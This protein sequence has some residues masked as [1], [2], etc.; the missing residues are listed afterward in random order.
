MLHVLSHLQKLD[1]KKKMD[2]NRNG[3]LLGKPVGDGKREK[4]MERKIQP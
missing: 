1:L 2:T 3:G 4:R